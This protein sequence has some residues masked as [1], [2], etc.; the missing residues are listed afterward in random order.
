MNYYNG[1]K[2]IE[3]YYKPSKSACGFHMHYDYG[4][5][6]IDLDG[7]KRFLNNNPNSKIIFPDGSYLRNAWMNE[8]DA[9][10]TEGK[11]HLNGIEISFKWE[12]GELALFEGREWIL[13]YPSVTEKNLHLVINTFALL[14]SN[15]KK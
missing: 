2:E 15:V 11:E 1:R 4:F 10:I 13:I 8:F 6:E 14:N 7:A 9:S 5:D 12:H 3:I